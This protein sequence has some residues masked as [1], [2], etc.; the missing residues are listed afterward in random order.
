MGWPQTGLLSRYESLWIQARESRLGSPIVA[1]NTDSSLVDRLVPPS[2]RLGSYV[3]YTMTTH[4]VLSYSLVSSQHCQ[5]F[6]SRTSQ[7]LQR[8]DSC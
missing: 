8:E 1:R 5:T 2:P 6:Y 4:I 3:S 7:L